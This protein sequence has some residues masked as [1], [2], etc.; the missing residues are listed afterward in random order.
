MLRSRGDVSPGRGAKERLQKALTDRKIPEALAKLFVAPLKEKYLDEVSYN[1][2]KFMRE[3]FG[4][5]AAAS[6]I[7]GSLL[8]NT[9]ANQ[10]GLIMLPRYYGAWGAELGIELGGKFTTSPDLSKPK[11]GRRYYLR[12]YFGSIVDRL[13]DDQLDQVEGAIKAALPLFKLPPR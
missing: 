7:F 1:V 11:E 8:G 6:D 13:T 9:R 12:Y 5:S 10:D 3:A 4:L 2:A